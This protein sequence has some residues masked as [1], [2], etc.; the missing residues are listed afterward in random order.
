[1]TSGASTLFGSLLSSPLS[2]S[3]MLRPRALLWRRLLESSTVMMLTSHKSTSR[4]LRSRLFLRPQ[5]RCIMMS[6]G[7]CNWL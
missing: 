2:S 5:N 4:I 6:A 1:G 7:T 3:S